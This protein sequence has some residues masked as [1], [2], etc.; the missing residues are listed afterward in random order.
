MMDFERDLEGE[1]Q[2]CVVERAPKQR[3]NTIEAVEQRVS[4]QVH[5]TS[6]LAEVAIAAEKALQRLDQ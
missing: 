5:H 1:A 3:L 6:R 2:F 4:V